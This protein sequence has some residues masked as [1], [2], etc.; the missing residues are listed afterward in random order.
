MIPA[1]PCHGNR[2]PARRRGGFTLIELILAVGMIAIAMAAINGALFGAIRLRDRTVDAVE[3]AIP[4]NQAMT[5]MRRDLLSVMPAGGTLSGDF[6]VG[7]I[8]SPGVTETV[9]L[10]MYCSNG[11]LRTNEP[12]GDVQRVTYELKSPVNPAMMGGGRDLVRSVTR[13]LLATVTPTPKEQVLLN[14]VDSV[15]FLCFDGSTW[16]SVWDT[17]LNN[18][19]LPVAVRVKI[20]PHVAFSAS[21]EERMPLELLVPIITLSAT[22]LPPNP[23]ATSN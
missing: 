2:R 17:T 7:Q 14:G 9:N 6:K 19:N 12:W 23:Y 20:H 13:N 5:I 3:T 21:I 8:T 10:E 11:A 22:N 4:V 15:E 16:Q 1:A 18:T